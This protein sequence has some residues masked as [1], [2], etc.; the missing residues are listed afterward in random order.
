MGK[1]D[2]LIATKNL[3]DIGTIAGIV[4]IVVVAFYVSGLV[5]NILE[6]KKLNAD[7]KEIKS[8]EKSLTNA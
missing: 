7:I 4:T 5:V 8:Q 3:K 2:N 6:I 1:L